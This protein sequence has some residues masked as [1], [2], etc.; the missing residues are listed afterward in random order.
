PDSS[1]AGAQ[2]MGAVATA[3]ID[4]FI[5]HAPP[6]MMCDLMEFDPA[7][8]L[9]APSAAGRQV[10]LKQSQNSGSPLAPGNFG[11]L[12][13]PDGSAGAADIE[14]ALAAV[15]PE[16]CYCLTSALMGQASRIA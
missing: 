3:G 16:D 8:D 1:T 12:S 5:C 10:Q 13:L 7:Q 11:L 2:S 15:E 14:R 4:P 9:T 6:L